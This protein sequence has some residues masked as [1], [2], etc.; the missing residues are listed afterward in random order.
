MRVSHA[1]IRPSRMASPKTF[2]YWRRR[3]EKRMTPS[4]TQTSSTSQESGKE[5]IERL[6]RNFCRL[7]GN[8]VTA[9]KSGKITRAARL[10]T[11]LTSPSDTVFANIIG[12]P[13]FDNGRGGRKLLVH[14]QA[15]SNWERNKIQFKHG[16]SEELLA[17]GVGRGEPRLR[18]HGYLREGTKQRLRMSRIATCHAHFP[19]T[20]LQQVPG[21]V[22][23]SLLTDSARAG[24]DRSKA[25]IA[26]ASLKQVNTHRKHRTQQIEEMPRTGTLKK[27]STET[28]DLCTSNTD[29]TLRTGLRGYTE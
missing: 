28:W 10:E 2:V 25:V 27:S 1:V 15:G 8:T 26:E 18:F 19:L 23:P 13:P 29:T 4:T 16:Y 22:P 24:E 6:K 11:S 21:T 12:K 14:S 20:N 9:D 5:A 17:W 7:S 3:S